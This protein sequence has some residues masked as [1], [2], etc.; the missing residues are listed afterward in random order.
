MMLYFGAH[1]RSEHRAVLPVC[2]VSRY[3]PDDCTF[4][5]AV[6]LNRRRLLRRSDT[7]RGKHESCGK[8][9]GL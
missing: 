7:Q 4:D 1:G 3:R 6:V 8:K 9:S 2:H 5:N